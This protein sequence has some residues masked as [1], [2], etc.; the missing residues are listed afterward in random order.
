MT[1]KTCGN[2]KHKNLMPTAMPCVACKEG[3]G[4]EP[5]RWAA[6]T[7]DVIRAIGVAQD[8]PAKNKKLS[9]AIDG[10]R[11]RASAIGLLLTDK[12]TDIDDLTDAI[13]QLEGLRL[14]WRELLREAEDE[15]GS[16]A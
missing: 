1:G 8:E 11:S 14:D 13:R 12:G 7:D 2:C 5:S 6:A 4:L 16:D 3:E 10:I 15:Q 9:Y